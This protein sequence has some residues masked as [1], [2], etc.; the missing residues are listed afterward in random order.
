MPEEIFRR[1]AQVSRNP[2]DIIQGQDNAVLRLTA[3]ATA[4]TFP[5]SDLQAGP[6]WKYR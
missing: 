4:I 1:D 2:V 6:G 3:G 5:L